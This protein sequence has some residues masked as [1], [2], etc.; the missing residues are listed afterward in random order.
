MKFMYQG[1]L[2]NALQIHDYHN[3]TIPK[4]CL[5]SSKDQQLPWT[6]TTHVSN[7]LGNAC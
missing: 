1:G 6:Q 2:Q 7:K 3:I 5:D 4:I